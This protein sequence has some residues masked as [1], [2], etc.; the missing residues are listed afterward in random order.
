MHKPITKEE[1]MQEAFNNLNA[2]K[3][4]RAL[5]QVERDRGNHD[6]ASKHKLQ[7]YEC[8]DK[9]ELSLRGINKA[10]RTE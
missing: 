9:L 6:K 8:I 2:F 3:R 1:L 4:S 10:L 5:E 7:Q